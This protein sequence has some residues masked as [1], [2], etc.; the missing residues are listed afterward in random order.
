MIISNNYQVNHS[1]GPVGFI[2]QLLHDHHHRHLDQLGHPRTFPQQQGHASACFSFLDGEHAH[3]FELE[4]TCHLVILFINPCRQWELR[5]TFLWSTWRSATSYSAAS[6][7]LSPWQT[8]SLPSGS[9]DLRWWD[10][11]ISLSKS[12]DLW[13]L[14]NYV[15]FENF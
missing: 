4:A 9:W 6:Q 1:W 10:F 7:S 13:L 14:L 5:E 12:F 11:F 3:S 15:L 2:D 8:P